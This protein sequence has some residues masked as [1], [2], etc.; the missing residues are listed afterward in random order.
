MSNFP[1]FPAC[2][3]RPGETRIFNS[4]EDLAAAGDGWADSP[5]KVAVVTEVAVELPPAEE[6]PEAHASGADYSNLDKADLVALAEAEGVEIDGRW[7]RTK[8]IAALEAAAAA[9]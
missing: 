6:A 1:E 3:Y 5:V 2:R 9:G 8:I 4:A 7:N